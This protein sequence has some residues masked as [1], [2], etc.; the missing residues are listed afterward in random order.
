[1]NSIR[2][3]QPSIQL[4]TKN[5]Q[6]D[7]KKVPQDELKTSINATARTIPPLNTQQP[8]NSTAITPQNSKQS[9][10]GQLL[11]QMN[12]LQRL[13]TTLPLA[14]TVEKSSPPSSISQ[15]LSQLLLPANQAHLIRWLQQGAGKSALIELLLQTKNPQSPLHQWLGQLPQQQQ[16]EVI[17]L[18]KL[19]AEQRLAPPP[20][21][22]D[23]E[24]VLVYWPLLQQTGK[25]AKLW[26][27]RQPQATS[28][29]GQGKPKWTVKL[30][31]PMAT[32]DD[33]EAIAEWDGHQ[34]GLK[35]ESQS[36]ALIDRTEQLSPF[37][38]A[39]L[40]QLGLTAKS[41]QFNVV[42]TTGS[43]PTLTA[44]ILVKV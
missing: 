25:E 44:G 8:T 1:M 12:V 41:V 13:F 11:Q 15:L 5:G 43:E 39:R 10:I 36:Q 31:L 28:K 40:E 24:V 23:A 9:Q 4:Q 14:F 37:L 6:A 42:P 29:P 3:D 27:Q 35:F 2:S 16:E 33:L 19:A 7:V 32:N 18:L 30:T 20:T 26:I 21:T 22:K 17:A 38:L 34:F